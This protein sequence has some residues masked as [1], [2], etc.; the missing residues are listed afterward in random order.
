METEDAW[1]IAS[2]RVSVISR[3]PSNHSIKLPP[4]SDPAEAPAPAV[5]GQP[6]IE[7]QF[8]DGTASVDDLLAGNSGSSD[9]GMTNSAR[10]QRQTTAVADSPGGSNGEIEMPEPVAEEEEEPPL[11]NRNPFLAPI[12]GSAGQPIPN[13]AIDPFLAGTLSEAQTPMNDTFL[14]T[15]AP[16]VHQRLDLARQMDEVGRATEPVREEPEGRAERSDDEWMEV[17]R[18]QSAEPDNAQGENRHEVEMMYT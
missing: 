1:E 6:S 10:L 4:Q 3:K 13:A 15:L 8:G 7:V 17:D 12:A 5:P 18:Q 2:R 9:E 14:S 16:S 11:D